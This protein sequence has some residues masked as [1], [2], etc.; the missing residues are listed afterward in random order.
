MD[1]LKLAKSNVVALERAWSNLS[2]RFAVPTSNLDDK[3]TSPQ[4]GRRTR[5]TSRLRAEVVRR[6]EAGAPSREVAEELGI[7]KATV[8]KVLRTEGVQLKPMGARY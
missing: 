2:A 7:G 6:Y 8:L 3:A 5:V 4:P 1:L